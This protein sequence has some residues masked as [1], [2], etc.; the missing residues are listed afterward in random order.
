MFDGGLK[1]KKMCPKCGYRKFVVSQH[2]V[3]SIIVD[4]NGNFIGEISSCDEIT[5]AADDDDMWTCNKCGYSA[6]GSEFNCIGI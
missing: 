2:V 3:Q 4:E 5:H 1:M 6:A